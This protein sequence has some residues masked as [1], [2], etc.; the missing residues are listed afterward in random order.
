MHFQIFFEFVCSLVHI[1]THAYMH[2][3]QLNLAESN[4]T[5]LLIRFILLG[6]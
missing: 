2:T 1:V 6:L 5:S 4:W 3:S